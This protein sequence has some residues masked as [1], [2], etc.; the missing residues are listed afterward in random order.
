[1][2][3]TTYWAAVKKAA[4]ELT[5]V[6]K[7][8]LG[9]FGNKSGVDEALKKVEKAPEGTK[10]E[11]AALYAIVAI[12]KY[13]K[14]VHEKELKSKLTEAQQKNMKIIADGLRRIVVDLQDIANGNKKGSELSDDQDKIQRHAEKAADPA[15]AE[16]VKEAK[17]GVARRLWA[18]KEFEKNL[19]Q[20]EQLKT[21]VQV[22]QRDAV[23]MAK[24]ARKAKEERDVPGLAGAIQEAVRCADDAEALVEEA[25]KLAAKGVDND[26][27]ELHKAYRHDPKVIEKLP[28]ALKTKYIQESRKA[29]ELGFRT[30]AKMKEAAGEVARMADEARSHALEAQSFSLN[31]DINAYQTALKRIAEQTKPMATWMGD[32]TRELD[33]WRENWDGMLGNDS[34]PVEARQLFLQDHEERVGEYET[35]VRQYLVQANQLHKQAQFIPASLDQQLPERKKAIDDLNKVTLATKPVVKD[36]VWAKKAIADWTKRLGG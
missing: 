3:L 35:L 14:D 28:T 11:E 7:I 33:G 21:Q 27:S 31:A 6:K 25:R 10:R 17:E 29:F 20:I 16:Q 12:Q 5:E 22:H 8:K 34:V 19:K 30:V 15:V 26:N 2:S 24:S 13:K 36:L 9:L 23:Q 1:M 32:R 18:A 4:E